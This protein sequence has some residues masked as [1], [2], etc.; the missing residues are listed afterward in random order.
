MS[1]FTIYKGDK[2]T[3]GTNGINGL[4]VDDVDDY[5]V[6]SPI[7]NALLPNDLSYNAFV[8]YENTGEAS[9]TD[10]YGVKRWAKKSSVTN[11]CQWSNDLSQWTDVF[12]YYTYTGTT[13]DPFGGSNASEINLDIDTDSTI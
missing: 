9:Y 2:G 1:I 12:G 11:F 13:A 3:A 8:T 5:I 10:R 6:G 7:T 4:N